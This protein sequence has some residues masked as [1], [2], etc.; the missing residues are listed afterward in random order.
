MV[1]SIAFGLTNTAKSAVCIAVRIAA[2]TFVSDFGTIVK[3][4][5]ARI[6]GVCQSCSVREA[7]MLSI[8]AWS[9]SIK[10]LA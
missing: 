2:A 9:A 3:S 4:G 10:A 7:A 1:H 8:A 5:K 6:C